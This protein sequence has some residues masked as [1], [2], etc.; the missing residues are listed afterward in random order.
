MIYLISPLLSR[1]FVSPSE[2]P[3]RGTIIEWFEKWQQ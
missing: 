3:V 2:H 1:V